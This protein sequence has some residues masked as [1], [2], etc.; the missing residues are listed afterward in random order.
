M[1]AH[2]ATETDVEAGTRRAADA[3]ATANAYRKQPQTHRAA[4]NKQFQPNDVS[5]VCRQ[6]GHPSLG[7]HLLDRMVKQCRYCHAL[8]WLEERVALLQMLAMSLLASNLLH[9]KHVH[10]NVHS[11]P[12]ANASLCDIVALAHCDS[13]SLHMVLTT[14]SMTPC[15][16]GCRQELLK[17]LATLKTHPT[18]AHAVLAARS[19]FLPDPHCPQPCNICTQLKMLRQSIPEQTPVASTP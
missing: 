19:A 8:M 16:Y 4:C 5:G 2:R 7:R 17:A 15:K 3:A 18:L 14:T 10:H 1:V 12:L 9:T 13:R 6:A 11:T